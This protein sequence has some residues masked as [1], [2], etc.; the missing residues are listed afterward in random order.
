MDYKRSIPFNSVYISKKEIYFVNDAINSRKLSDK[1]KY[2]VLCTEWLKKFVKVKECFLVPSCTSGLEMSALLINI[3]P[4]DEIIVPNYTF[5]STPNAFTIFGAKI[6]F[7]DIEKKS[8]NINFIEVEKAISK[9]TKAIVV[10]HYAGNSAKMEELKKIA[11]KYNLYLI[12]DA[13]Q[14]FNSYYK[15]QPVGIYGDISIFSFHVSKN[16][17]SG[18]EGGLLCV[19]NQELIKKAFHISEKGTNKRN[20][21]SGSVK[22]Y[23]WISKGSSYKM[24]EIQA[25]FLYAQLMNLKKI[26]KKRDYIWNK[27]YK[28]LHNLNLP[29]LLPEKCNENQHNSHIFHIRL[30]SQFLREDLIDFAKKRS[31]EMASHYETLHNS[32]A[33]KLYGIS[34]GKLNHSINASNNLIRLPIHL[35]LKVKDIEIVVKTIRDFFKCKN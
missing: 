17:T 4:G 28:L 20:F 15:K 29:I 11:R 7:V 32:K 2:N 23:T 3:K 21:I 1:S 35:D 10:V 24:S 16:I 19:N 22:K 26:Q 33:G 12:E 14:A 6:V 13:A 18:G 5:V 34:S 30:K 27:Y 31:V 9:K 25:A 8:L